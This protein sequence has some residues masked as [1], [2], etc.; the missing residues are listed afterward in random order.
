[1]ITFHLLE[2]LPNPEI[3]SRSPVFQID[4]LP[5]EPPGEPWYISKKEYSLYL[6]LSFWSVWK[7]QI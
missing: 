1:M 4:S 3:E 5:S 7:T 2:D 6:S